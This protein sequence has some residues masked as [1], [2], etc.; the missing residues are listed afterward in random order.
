METS[1]VQQ[2]QPLSLQPLREKIDSSE[3]TAGVVEAVDEA[4]RH[5]GTTHPEHDRSCRG[6]PLSGDCRVIANR[7]EYGYPVL[8]QIGHKRRIT[9]MVALRR[10]EFN[11]HILA[12]DITGFL[13]AGMKSRDLLAVRLHT[14][15]HESNHRHRRLLRARR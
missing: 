7:N 4:E 11:C 3:I 14:G 10:A 1:F 6:G 9:I 2:A 13:E 5:W 8:Q 15:N 12:L